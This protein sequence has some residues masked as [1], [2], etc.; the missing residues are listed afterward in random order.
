MNTYSSKFT[1][2]ELHN[3]C[4]NMQKF[5]GSFASHLGRALSHA[6]TQNIIKIVNT[7][8]DLIEE[9]TKFNTE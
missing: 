5:G 4:E 1:D 7:W 6:D 3:A 2:E 8:P 9:Y